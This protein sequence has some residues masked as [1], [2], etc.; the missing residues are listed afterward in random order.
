MY[1]LYG[2]KNSQAERIISSFL[3]TINRLQG[4]N[5]TS[6]G[7][8]DQ[9]RSANLPL[10]THL[11]YSPVI[12]QALLL[13]HRVIILKFRNAAACVC[14]QMVTIV[15]KDR[16]RCV[17][18]ERLFLVLLAISRS[19]VSVADLKERKHQ[20]QEEITKKC[21]Y[22]RTLVGTGIALILC[23]EGVFYSY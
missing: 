17:L 9:R 1:A 18:S 8:D 3:S 6:G 13:G 22:R 2:Q 19:H 23:A 7:M 12:C 16:P 11:I 10:G 21:R 14:V 20:L 15:L 5:L 4:R